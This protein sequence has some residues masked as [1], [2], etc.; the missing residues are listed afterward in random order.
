HQPLPRARLALRKDGQGALRQRGGERAEGNIRRGR[1]LTDAAR[2]R[3]RD[4]ISWRR[5]LSRIRPADAIFALW[6]TGFLRSV[7]PVCFSA[8]VQGAPAAS[9]GLQAKSSTSRPS[10]QRIG[11]G[12]ARSHSAHSA[13]ASS[14][15]P[16]CA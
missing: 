7:L 4:E 13:S 11:V 1:V 10:L 8:A 9:V 3:L 15:P 16:P 6:L 2:K 12:A 14:D 5:F